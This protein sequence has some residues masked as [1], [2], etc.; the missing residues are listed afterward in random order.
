MAALLEAARRRN[1]LP[2]G[3]AAVGVG[4]IVAGVS[5]YGFL[6]V[7]D[8]ALSKTEYS[9]LGALW[10]LVFLAGPGLFLPFEQEISRALA[11]RRARGIGGAPVGRRG[12]PLG[13][14]LPLGVLVL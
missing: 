5:A 13:V 3:T 10:S 9:P 11:E 7:A 14:G 8:K 6:F 4:L 2:S 12:A 1:P